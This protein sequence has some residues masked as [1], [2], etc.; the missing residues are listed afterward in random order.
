M[1]K[2]EELKNRIKKFER[3]I[4]ET[5]DK[6]GCDIKDPRYKILSKKKSNLEILYKYWV[7]REIAKY[8]NM[9][10]WTDV[11]PFEVVKTISDQT[12]EV[13]PMKAIPVK[14][15]A[16]FHPGGFVG[17][18]SDN[19]SQEYEYKSIPEADVIRVRWSEAKKQWQANG[20]SRFVMN[21][22]PVYFHD[23]NF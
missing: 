19:Y 5:L 22:N 20:G 21:D 16:E 1:K 11:H 12:V 17:H 13:R 14:V 6:N 7:K 15:P 4:S 9:H 3:Q 23:Y 8:C 10:L 18:Y 2:S